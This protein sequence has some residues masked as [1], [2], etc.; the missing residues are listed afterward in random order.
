MTVTPV[1]LDV[2]ALTFSY[3]GQP[4]LARDWSTTIRAG[5]TLMHGDTGC[6]KSTLLRLLAGTERIA[7]RLTLAGVRLDVD[8]V[9]YR[10][11]VFFVDPSDAAQDALIARD[12]ISPAGEH[13]AEGFAL[14]PH[15]HKPM[16]MLSTGT[17]RKVWLAAALTSTCPLTLLDEPAGA[18][19]AASRDYLAHALGAL[20]HQRERAIVVASSQ[21][22]G[23]VP[24]AGT[25]TLPL[26]GA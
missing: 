16:F 15:L 6:G 11:S 22:L 9:A 2:Q 1:I 24:L 12:V 8:A 7:G 21:T 26:Q 18:L 4:P 17:R 3:A 10:R 14:G 13:H 19:D 23:A 25:I 5:V 20:A